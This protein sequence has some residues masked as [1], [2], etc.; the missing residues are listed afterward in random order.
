MK[1]QESKA[2]ERGREQ[3]GGNSEKIGNSESECEK[4]K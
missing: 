2:I 1:R 4:E 3:V